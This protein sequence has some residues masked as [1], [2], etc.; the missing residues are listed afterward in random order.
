LIKH[1]TVSAYELFAQA[2]I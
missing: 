1:F 2:Q